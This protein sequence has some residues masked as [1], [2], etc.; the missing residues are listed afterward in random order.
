M[1]K[2]FLIASM[3]V[4]AAIC[5]V[6]ARASVDADI[7]KVL[8]DAIPA[9][10]NF[11]EIE[12]SSVAIK[13]SNETVIIDCND[14]A[15]YLPL[16]ESGY[17]QLAQDILAVLGSRCRN[18]RLI[19]NSGGKKLSDLTLFADKA[20]KGP[21][22]DAP[23]ITRID[24]VQAPKGLQNAN[25]ALW[26][27]HG[28]YFE[29]KLNRWEWQRARIFETVEDLYTQSYVMPYLMPMLENAGAYV[30][31]PRERDT[32]T[33]EAVADYDS[34][35][36]GGS[37]SERGHWKNAG[38]PG[39]SHDGSRLT[40][41]VNPFSKGNVRIAKASDNR[42]K[43]PRVTWSFSEAPRGS[44]AIYV[45]YASLPNSATDA[46][47][48]IHAADADHQ[49][50][51]NQRMGGGTWIYLGHFDIDPERAADG[52]IELSGYSADKDAVITA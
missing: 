25:I 40:E 23:F 50:K 30:M 27:S 49:V 24:G 17:R 41:G 16:T 26:Q 43:A 46:T 37:F 3:A 39:F 42:D 19:I 45:S 33:F 28:W 22:G 51:V 21:Q 12:V 13:A 6:P 38:T 52:L 1:H 4:L 9:N 47:Y 18:Y 32:S 14:A 10:Y 29:P 15:S 36:N 34:S 20:L 11:G 7:A 35:I 44:H 48:T 8:N 31:S 5:T 2:K